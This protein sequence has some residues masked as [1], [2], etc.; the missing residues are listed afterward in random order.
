M[1]YADTDPTTALNNAET[2]D[3]GLKIEDAIRDAGAQVQVVN[4][5]W[6]QVVGD[7]HYGQ[8]QD[9]RAAANR[10]DPSTQNRQGTPVP[11]GGTR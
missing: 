1:S 2:I 10:Q 9:D 11:T 4:W 3:G 8:Y 5:I 6:E 7:E